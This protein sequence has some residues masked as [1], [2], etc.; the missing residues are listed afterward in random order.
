MEYVI[1]DTALSGQFLANLGDA[2]YYT[3][4]YKSSDSAYEEDLKIIPNDDNVLN[5]Y[6]YYLSVRD[7]E[8]DKAERMSKKSIFLS[9]NNA[10]YLDTYAWILY[11]EG[12][13]KDAK[14]WEEKSLGNGGIGDA[15]V[16][17]HYG[18]ILYKLGDKD[19]ALENWQKA[20]DM[21]M[22]SDLLERKIR[23]KQLYDK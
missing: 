22:K 13:Y 20:K 8:L 19:K 7:T 14:Y 1:S 4:R 6:S 5:N 18:D 2:Y 17:E 9:P 15:T 21:G 3:K 23:D 12:K 11:M 10:S 16:V